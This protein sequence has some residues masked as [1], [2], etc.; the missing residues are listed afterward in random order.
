MKI[1]GEKLAKLKARAGR[2]GK[3]AA[4]GLKKSGMNALAGGVAYFVHDLGA[5][6]ITFV[7]DNWWAG[8]L[9]LFV[10]GHFTKKKSGDLGAGLCGAAGYAAVMGY[11][12]TQSAK[13]AGGGATQQ[14][15]PNAGALEG[16]YADV[17]A[18]PADSGAPSAGAPDAGALVQGFDDED[19]AWGLYA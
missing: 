10:I 15:A 1:S 8:P 19:E 3:N 11:K 14:P 2:A 9:G 18:M 13:V 6:H 16:A 5:Q 4:A 7:R 12:M 17:G